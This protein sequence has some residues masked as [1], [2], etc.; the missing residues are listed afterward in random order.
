M[1]ISE[2]G[3]KIPLIKTKGNFTR[4]DSIMAFAGVSVGVAEIS[5]PRDEKQKAANMVPKINGMLTI[6]SPKTKRLMINTAVVIK[7]P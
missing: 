1:P 4:V 7:R 2:R 6:N 5:S 3:T